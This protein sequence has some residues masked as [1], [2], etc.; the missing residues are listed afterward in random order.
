MR[1]G[2]DNWGYKHMA[3]SPLRW[4]CVVFTVIRVHP[5]TIKFTPRWHKSTAISSTKYFRHL[6]CHKS[7]IWRNGGRAVQRGKWQKRDPRSLSYITINII[8]IQMAMTFRW[9]HVFIVWFP[10][11]WQCEC[12]F[13]KWVVDKDNPTMYTLSRAFYLH[14]V[15]PLS[16][17]KHLV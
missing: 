14:P 5:K 3:S 17:L 16:C 1:A 12:M 9:K 13:V 10:Y 6:N 7:T 4:P 15:L 2:P 8:Y 11:K